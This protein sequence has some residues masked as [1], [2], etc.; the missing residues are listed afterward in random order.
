MRH[1]DSSLRTASGNDHSEF[2]DQSTLSWLGG[3]MVQLSMAVG[4]IIS[5]L[6]IL[7][8]LVI[9][10]CILYVEMKGSSQYR[11]SLDNK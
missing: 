9:G 10:C 7:Y 6:I 4:V 11:Q 5:N 2:R 1:C 8:F 3:R